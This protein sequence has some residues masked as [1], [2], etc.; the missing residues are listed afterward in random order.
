MALPILLRPDGQSFSL[1][2]WRA[3][4]AAEPVERVVMHVMR[5]AQHGDLPLYAW[6]LG[7][8][9]AD[10]LALLRG[11][12]PELPALQ[13][14]PEASYRL[15]HAQVPPRMQALARKLFACRAFG[16]GSLRSNALARALA[17]A[18]A[19]E[20]ELWQDAG[21]SSPQA[22][23]PLLQACFTGLPLDAGQGIGKAWLWRWLEQAQ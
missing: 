11:L 18:C 16:T 7:L 20:E 3:Q 4:D 8:S 13:G 19:G 17:M 14:M 23:R 2:G 15:L 6:T 5:A 21:L 1:A 10:L 22:L 12:F 9:Q